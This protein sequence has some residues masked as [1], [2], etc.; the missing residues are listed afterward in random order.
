MSIQQKEDRIVK[1]LCP[2][3]HT[4]WENIKLTTLWKTYG[5]RFPNDQC[6]EKGSD[7]SAV[8][9]AMRREGFIN[10]QMKSTKLDARHNDLKP[11]YQLNTN[12]A[13]WCPKKCQVC[14]DK[15]KDN[16]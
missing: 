2:F 4:M 6:I 11:T 12:Q 13:S 14:L 3:G 5:L 7:Y 9:N 15:A 8:K 16:L 1:V 10:K